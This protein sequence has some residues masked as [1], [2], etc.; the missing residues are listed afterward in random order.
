MEESQ[1]IVPIGY[2]TILL[3]NLC[4]DDNVREKVCSRLPSG[5]ID[6]LIQKIREFVLYNQKVDRLAGK[7][8]GREG[9]ERHRNFT[10]RL[11]L[12][13]DRLEMVGV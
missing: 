8:E 4:L 11:M 7:F 10:A 2:L 13:V 9:E 5:K 1:L 3:G 12:V 6:M